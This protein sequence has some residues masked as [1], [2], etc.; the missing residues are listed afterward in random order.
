MFRCALFNILLDVRKLT[1]LSMQQSLPIQSVFDELGEKEFLNAR[2]RS[3]P[4]ESIKGVIFQNR[5]ILLCH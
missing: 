3:N 5:Y 2:L 4:F 1:T